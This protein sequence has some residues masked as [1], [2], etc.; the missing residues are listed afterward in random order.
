VLQDLVELVLR[1]WCDDTNRLVE[2][3][4]HQ[5][6]GRRDEEQREPIDALERDRGSENRAGEE[7]TW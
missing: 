7:G 2:E 4:V 3:D 6:D 5:G 1:G